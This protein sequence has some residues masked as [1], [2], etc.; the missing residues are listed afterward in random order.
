[1]SETE[2]VSTWRDM[3]ERYHATWCTLDRVL[4]E[5]HEIGATEFEVLEHLAETEAA[6][7][8]DC[9]PTCRMQ[10][11]GGRVQLSQSALSRVV[12]R[13][14]KDRLVERAMCDADRRGIYVRLTAAG[15][16]RHAEAIPTHRTIL[17]ENLSDQVV[18]R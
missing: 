7:P 15:R 9:E 6:R 8:E 18:S 16:A 4:R 1:M 13:L 11:L 2:L 5:R 14:E 10:D 17:A 3:L 12:S